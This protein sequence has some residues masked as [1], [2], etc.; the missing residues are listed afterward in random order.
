MEN[1]TCERNAWKL[2]TDIHNNNF[3]R[4]MLFSETRHRYFQMGDGKSF[5]PPKATHIRNREITHRNFCLP[6]L[7]LHSSSSS[8][9]QVK[10][11]LSA[12]SSQRCTALHSLC[13]ANWLTST[14]IELFQYLGEKASICCSWFQCCSTQCWW[15]ARQGN[16]W[17]HLTSKASQ[18]PARPTALPSL[19][20]A[21][22]V[23]C[24]YQLQPFSWSASTTGLKQKI[25]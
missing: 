17:A 18:S 25:N 13:R 20:Q 15:Q 7:L 23:G 4:S 11:H 24:A 5:F 14:A 9:A 8:V 16:F 21:A 19:G 1:G 3:P 2:F 22:P 10:T 6:F 12:S